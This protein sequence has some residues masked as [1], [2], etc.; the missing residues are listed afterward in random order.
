MSF[1]LVAV[2]RVDSLAVVRGFL[3]EVAF[4]VGEHGLQ[5][6]QASGVVAG[7]LRGCSSQAPEQRLQ[8]Q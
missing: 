5:A 7:G 2:S 1:S 6:T 4:L 8:A 3:M